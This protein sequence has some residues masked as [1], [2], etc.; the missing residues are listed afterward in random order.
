MHTL[1]KN[2]KL[3]ELKIVQWNCFKLT[4][5][6]IFELGEFLKEF[7]PDIISIQEI[8]MNQEQANLFLR[9]DGYSVHYRPR[10]KNADFGGGTAVIVKDSIAHVAIVDLDK[11]L[12]HIGVKI[13]TNDFNFNLVSL[14]S[15]LNTLKF[16]TVKKYSELGSE[17]FILGDLNAKT[18]TVGCRSLDNNGKV[19]DEILSSDLDLC[20]L[21]DK[22]PTYFRFNSDYS[23]I[24]DLFLCSANLANKM[25]HFEVLTD[26]LMGSDHA[27]ILCIL[28]LDKAFRIDVRTPEPRFNFTKA[29]WNKYGNILDEMIGQIDMEGEFSDLSDFN[30]LSKKF[31]S[32]IINTA[33]QTVPKLLNRQLKSYPPHIIEII[34]MRRDARKIRKKKCLDQKGIFSAEYNRLT[35]ILRKAIKEYTEKKWAHFLGKLGPYPASSSVFWRIISRA[36]SPKKK[37][38]IPDLVVGERVFRSDEE[39]AGLFRAVL[40]ETFTDSGPSTDFDAVIYNYVENFVSNFDYSDDQYSK[41]SLSEM[42][43]VIRGL[44]VDSSPGEDGVHNQFLK[45]L[46]SKGLGLLLKM[47]NLSFVVGLQKD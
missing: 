1:S 33:N 5:A 11:D 12:D 43:E 26:H 45:Y 20:V 7:Q 25:S 32:L 8:K 6:R 18:R 2:L 13:V 23:E 30:D 47:V 46:S 34:D 42:V 36:R 44:R 15:P 39:K 21:N 4:Q 10:N 9:L 19:L 29:D 37:V 40:G 27:P 35:G 28:S 38:G 14:Y 22:S 41:V 24:L 3:H 16:E 17:L 31:S